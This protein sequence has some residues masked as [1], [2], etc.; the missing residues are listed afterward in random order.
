MLISC[1]MVNFFSKDAE[2][3][4]DYFDELAQRP[5][6]CV[7]IED[8]ELTN[9]YVVEGEKIEPLFDNEEGELELEKVLKFEGSDELNV[10]CS[11]QEHSIYTPDTPLNA[12]PLEESLPI[13]VQSPIEL[14]NQILSPIDNINTPIKSPPLQDFQR[15]EL[16]DF[17]GLMVLI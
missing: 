13:I 8:F 5:Q 2:E 6:C 7:E 4:W 15:V 17:L 16:I 1:L 12:K 14:D 10:Q 11:P 3:S 9:S